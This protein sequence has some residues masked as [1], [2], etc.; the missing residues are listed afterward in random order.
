M[1][2]SK[3]NGI[4]NG[5]HSPDANPPHDVGIIGAELYFPKSYVDQEDLERVCLTVNTLYKNKN[6]YKNLV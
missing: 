1:N 5:N 6:I 3:E 4:L 2:F